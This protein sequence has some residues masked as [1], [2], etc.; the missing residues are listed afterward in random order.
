MFIVNKYIRKNKQIPKAIVI[1]RN[2]INES[3]LTKLR[4]T[5]ID[6]IQHAIKTYANKVKIDLKFVY[7]V[8]KK[9]CNFR[10][11]DHVT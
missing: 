8:V 10:M 2:G 7:I 3:D 4:E 1:Y 9:S 11:L 6:Q 5:E